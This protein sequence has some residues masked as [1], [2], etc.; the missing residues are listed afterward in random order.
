MPFTAQTDG[1]EPYYLYRR[2]PTSL[3]TFP[4]YKAH[5]P[6]NCLVSIAVLQNTLRTHFEN[7]IYLFGER[8][9]IHIHLL[10]EKQGDKILYLDQVYPGKEKYYR[11]T[12]KFK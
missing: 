7:E 5:R 8:R 9:H 3:V 12:N 6:G 10:F 1:S 11:E 4:Q 2:G